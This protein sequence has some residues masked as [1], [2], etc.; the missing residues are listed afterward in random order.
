MGCNLLVARTDV[1]FLVA[2]PRLRA[3]HIAAHA[4][5]SCRR[6][7]RYRGGA[8]DLALRGSTDSPGLGGDGNR[9][10]GTHACGRRAAGARRGR[11][12]AA[13]SRVSTPASYR[14]DG[15]TWRLEVADVAT[16]D[17]RPLEAVV[18]A[19]AGDGNELGGGGCCG[20]AA[21]DNDLQASGV[22]LRRAAVQ[23]DA[24]TR[25]PVKT[26]QRGIKEDKN[27]HFVTHE[28]FAG[29]KLGRDS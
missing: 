16:P 20:S 26:D 6:V 5:G 25:N 1:T 7:V 22:R 13:R 29:S 19:I 3:A 23:R 14:C 10:R 4:T 11:C 8:S 2:G 9:G 28:V 18:D 15:G 21:R 17:V 24:G 12:G 27:S